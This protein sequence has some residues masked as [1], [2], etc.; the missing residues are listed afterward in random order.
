[1]RGQRGVLGLC[2]HRAGLEPAEGI[3][4]HLGPETRKAGL[5][6]GCRLVRP[7]REAAGQE[8]GAGI[9]ALV[10]RHRGHPGLRQPLVDGPLDG[11]RAAKMRE[12]RAVDVDRPPGCDLDDRPGKDLSIGHDHLQ[13]GSEGAQRGLGLGLAHPPRLQDGNAVGL[14]RSVSREAGRD[15]RPRPL[16]LSG[17][18][19]RAAMRW[20]ASRSASKDGIANAP[21][22]RKTM[23]TGAQSSQSSFFARFLS[24]R[25]SRSRFRGVRRSTKSRPSMWSISW[26][27]ARARS[28]VAV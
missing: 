6:L 17:W 28:S 12:Q 19:T 7:D 25:F 11:G 21:L 2:A 4:E 22:P 9:E 5:E 1:M 8:D 18:V 3:D 10:D 23:R 27:N 26:Q 13:L 20:P 14:P 15:S 24:L 16:A